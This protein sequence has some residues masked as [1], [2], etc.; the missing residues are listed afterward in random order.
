MKIP[1]LRKQEEKKTCHSYTWEDDYSWIH[2]SNC[3]E[4]LQDKSKLNLEV[5]KYL[6]EENAIAP[7][8]TFSFHSFVKVDKLPENCELSK[9]ETRYKI[10]IPANKETDLHSEN[11]EKYLS[12]WRQCEDLLSKNCYRIKKIFQQTTL[13]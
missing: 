12:S 10:W 9:S 2:Q 11:G 7:F 13:F 5:K 1:Q 6:E 4:I 8:H 3:L